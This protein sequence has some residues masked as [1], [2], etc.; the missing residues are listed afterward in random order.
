MSIE[1]EILDKPYQAIN[2]LFTYGIDTN[3]NAGQTKYES[4]ILPL[5]SD[6]EADMYQKE[7]IKPMEC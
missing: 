1:V 5:F 7:W 3:I 6:R 4:V 2:R